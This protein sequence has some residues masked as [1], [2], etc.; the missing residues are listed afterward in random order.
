[1]NIAFKFIHKLHGVFCSTKYG[2]ESGHLRICPGTYG[3]FG[4]AF[5]PACCSPSNKTTAYRR[6]PRKVPPLRF[7]TS[8]IRIEYRLVVR[9]EIKPIP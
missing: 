6:S 2:I 9:P 8:R 5:P 1:M 4:N 3:S 7:A